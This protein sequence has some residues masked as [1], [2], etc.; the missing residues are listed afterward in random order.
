MDVLGKL[1]L[2]DALQV[3]DVDRDGLPAQQFGGL[4]PPAA[5]DQPAPPVHHHGVEQSHG[6]EGVGQRPHVPQ[7]LAVAGADL[8]RS[9]PAGV[10][11]GRGPD[12]VAGVGAGRLKRGRRCGPFR[13]GG[14]RFG[15][16][17]RAR[18]TT[19]P[20]RIRAGTARRI[21]A[22]TCC[23]SDEG[24]KAGLVIVLPRQ[25]GNLRGRACCSALFA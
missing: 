11:H 24:A 6:V 16:R 13:G 5:G 25:A 23:C 19:P 9:D 1:A 8:D 3:H 17:T 12:E 2:D 18:A 4:Q 20:G 22:P 21:Y 7:V 15:Y 10:G 14:W